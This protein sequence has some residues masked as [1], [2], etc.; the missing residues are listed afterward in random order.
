MNTNLFLSC[1]R[2]FSNFLEGKVI[3]I[4]L[5]Y[6][7]DACLSHTPFACLPHFFVAG[8]APVTRDDLSYVKDLLSE[9]WDF[10]MEPDQTAFN[11]VNAKIFDGQFQV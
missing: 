4:F 1:K 9:T 8:T 11:V 3:K 5:G 6:A 10:Q 2:A 7:P